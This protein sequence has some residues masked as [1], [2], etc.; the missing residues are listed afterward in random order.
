MKLTKSR[1]REIIREEIDNINEV[2]L[3][4]LKI[5]STVNRFLKRFVNSLQGANLSRMKQ[6]AVLYKVIDALG[7]DLSELRMYI[8]K[9]K[10]EM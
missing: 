3:E 7:L 6:V 8:Q 9:I 2:N 10:R 1:I 5:P 4:K